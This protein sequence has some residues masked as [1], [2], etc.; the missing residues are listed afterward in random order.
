MRLHS[1]EEFYINLQTH[2]KINNV[3]ETK[4]MKLQIKGNTII[5][6]NLFFIVGTCTTLAALTYMIVNLDKADSII[7]VWTPFMVAGVFLSFIGAFI[8]I[9]SSLSK[10]AKKSFLRF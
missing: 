9:L 8:F 5:V 4:N 6:G 7:T 10:S 1:N 3:M 2:I